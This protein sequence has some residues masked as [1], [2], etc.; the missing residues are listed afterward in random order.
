LLSCNESLGSE[1]KKNKIIPGIWQL[2]NN[3][4]N[5]SDFSVGNNINSMKP[6]EEGRQ[7]HPLF[8]I[9]LQLHTLASHSMCLGIWFFK[10][11]PKKKIL[12]GI[13]SF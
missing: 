11:S 3:S 10:L 8:S 2:T 9:L 12:C 1:D 4:V 6:D 7:P 13:Y 5:A